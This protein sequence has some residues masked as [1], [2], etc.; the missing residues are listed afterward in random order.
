MVKDEQAF[1]VVEGQGFRELVQELQPK[2]GVPSRM[3]VT[4]DI[5]TNYFAMREQN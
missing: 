3:T 1:N 4:R 2:F 5:Y